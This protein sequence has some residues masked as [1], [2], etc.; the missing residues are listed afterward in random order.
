LLSAFG[1]AFT[2][3]TFAKALTLLDGTLLAPGRRTVASALRSV[4][5]LNDPHSTNYHR[6]LNRDHRSPWVLS[7]ILLSL[8]ISLCLA[9]DGPLILIIH[10][11]LSEPGSTQVMRCR[12]APATRIRT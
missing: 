7:K 11:T 5:L 9:P 1:V 6:V 2:S 8:I 3:R 12:P 4:G 10:D